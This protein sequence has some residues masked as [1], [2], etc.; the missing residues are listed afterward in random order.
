MGLQ[1]VG[2]NWATKHTGSFCIDFTIHHDFCFRSFILMR[3]TYGFFNTFTYNL[4]ILHF[5]GQI[6]PAFIIESSFS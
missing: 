5:F 3:M 1:R 2:Y 4:V 6:I